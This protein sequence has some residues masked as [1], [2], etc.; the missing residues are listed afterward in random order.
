M[1]PE[2]ESL[3]KC[4]LLVCLNKLAQLRT[5]CPGNDATHGGLGPPAPI[6]DG[7][8]LPQAGQSDFG[9]PSAEVY[10]VRRL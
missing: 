9:N 10:P 6:S 8:N 2:A 7:D 3:E 4:C 5:A 1:G